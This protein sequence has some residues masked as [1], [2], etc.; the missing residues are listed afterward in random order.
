[1]Y[2]A[3]IIEFT[4]LL[5]SIV[6]RIKLEKKY[7]A[8]KIYFDK[9]YNLLGFVLLFYFIAI[10]LFIY[11]SNSTNS[12]ILNFLASIFTICG[13]MCLINIYRGAFISEGYIVINYKEIKKNNCKILSYDNGILKIKDISSGVVFAI[14][15]REEV[16]LT[17]LGR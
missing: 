7:Q 10:S 5:Y 16:Y 1:M 6:K 13:I 15:S 8:K 12:G 2:L 3:M 4:L 17:L 9:K 11:F 14:K